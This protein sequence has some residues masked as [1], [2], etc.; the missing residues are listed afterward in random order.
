MKQSIFLKAA[1][2]TTILF[3]NVIPLLA[4]EDVDGVKSVMTIGK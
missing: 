2:I 3:V 1:I 4:T